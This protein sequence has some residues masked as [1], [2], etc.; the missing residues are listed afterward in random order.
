[1]FAASAIAAN[2]FMRSL[3]GAVFPLFASYMFNG[4]GI[5]WGMTLIGCIAA[6]LV[7]MPFIFFYKGRAIRARSK[8]APAP[9]I[10]LDRKRD[11]EMAAGDSDGM[12]DGSSDQGNSNGEKK[13]E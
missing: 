7:P 11:E 6:L 4:I 5:N 13:S 8:F 12:I 2:T 1:M 9:D 3:F 10:A